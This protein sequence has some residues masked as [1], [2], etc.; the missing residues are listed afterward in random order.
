M[1]Q[2]TDMIE[3]REHDWIEDRAEPEKDIETGL[4]QLNEQELKIFECSNG[5]MVRL[6]SN[7]SDMTNCSF[8]RRSWR[9]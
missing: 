3:E 8:P 4:E 9:R 7:L 6:A 5:S 2:D 1:S